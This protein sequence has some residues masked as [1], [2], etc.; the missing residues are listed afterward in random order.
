MGISFFR[1]LKYG[2]NVPMKV[3]RYRIKDSTKE[4]ELSKLSSNVNLVWNTCNDMI[5]KQ[6][7]ESRK[8]TTKAQLNKITRGASK[9]L[10]INQQTVQAISYELLLRIQKVKKQVRFRS[11]KK[12]L[13]W[14]PFNGQTMKLVGDVVFYNGMDFNLWITRPLCGKIKTGSF[15]CDARGRWYINFSCED[16]AE[17]FCGQGEIGLDLGM[18]STVTTS[19]AEKLKASRYRKWEKK[20]AMAQRACK[21][22]LART[23]HAK[24]KNSRKDAIEK[25]TTKIAEVN[26]LVVIGKMESKKLIKTFLAK[27]TY[28]NGW[29]MLKTRLSHKVVKHGGKYLEVPE[30]FTSRTCSHCNLGWI[31]PKGLK[32]LAIREYQ[33]PGC[34]SLQ[35]RDVNAARNIL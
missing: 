27:S 6:W 32:S 17:A 2:K 11:R 22:K 14:I 25:F 15:T 18:I 29:Y 5:R 9:E 23:I 19:Q 35:D 3:I 33:C 10:N 16:K 26:S 4:K 28:D 24:I 7:K 21:K 34:L 20:L 1:C 31:L 13:P 8:Y 12:S 30:N